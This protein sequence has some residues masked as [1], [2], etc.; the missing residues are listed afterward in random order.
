[1][2]RTWVGLGAAL[3]L[4]M[5]GCLATEEDIAQ[6]ETSDQAIVIGGGAPKAQ[7][8]LPEPAVEAFVLPQGPLPEPAVNGDKASIGIGTGGRIEEKAAIGIGTGGR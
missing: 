5:T 1:M 4:S 8:P 3:L 2:N 6:A 7:I